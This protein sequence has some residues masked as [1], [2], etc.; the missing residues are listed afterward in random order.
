MRHPLNTRNPLLPHTTTPAQHNPDTT[1]TAAAH[2][3]TMVPVR[4][5]TSKGRRRTCMGLHK[6]SSMGHSLD[7]G[8]QDR[9][10]TNRVLRRL[11]AITR[12]TGSRVVV[13]GDYLRDSAPG[14]RVVVAWTACSEQ[15]GEKGGRRG[16]K[17]R[18]RSR[19]WTTTLGVQYEELQEQGHQMSKR[20]ISRVRRVD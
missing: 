16:R 2:Q 5:R 12:I 4:I 20:R 3:T 17:R 15:G 6:D 14:W 9:C 11:E 1:I 19:I 8:S 10:S 7:M 13:G 18:G